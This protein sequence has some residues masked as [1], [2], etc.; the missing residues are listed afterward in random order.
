SS[1]ITSIRFVT[2]E[3]SCEQREEQR[4]RA[5]ASR[6][7]LDAHE[8]AMSAHHVVDDREPEAGALRTRAGVGLNP[9]ELAEDPALQPA[10]DAD[11]A[12]DDA[13][14]AVAVHRLDLDG[15]LAVLRR[16]FHRVRQ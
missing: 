7:A 2:V 9:E 4:E 6:L 16:V 15:D 14:R 12:I 8:S 3:F 11:A 13:D 10:R 5:A 1:S